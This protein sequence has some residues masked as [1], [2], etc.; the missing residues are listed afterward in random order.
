M[1]NILIYLS[2]PIAIL[3]MAQNSYIYAANFGSPDSVENTIEE[4]ASITGAV[5]KKRATQPWFDW[6]A[7]MQ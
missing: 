6:K 5:V 4:D 7:K 2:A 3:L 1:N